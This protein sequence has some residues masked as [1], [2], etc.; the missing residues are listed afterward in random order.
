MDFATRTLTVGKSKTQSGT[1]RV[2]PLN[3][4]S[5]VFSRFEQR[6]SQF[7]NPGHYVFPTEKYG[8]KGERQSF[9]FTAET[10]V[11]DSDPTKRIV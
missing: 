8:A 6:N 1:D 5:W 10:T 3:A 2:I 11:Y 7:V 9:G 4:E